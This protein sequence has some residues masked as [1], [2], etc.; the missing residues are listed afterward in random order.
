MDKSF[1]NAEGTIEWIATDIIC[2]IQATYIWWK[3]TQKLPYK[4]RQ[5]VTLSLKTGT[6]TTLVHFF[7]K[8]P[9]SLHCESPN[10]RW[11]CTIK[12][13][14]RLANFHSSSDLFY[15]RPS[16]SN[17]H[18]YTEFQPWNH[19]S[20]LPHLS[21]TTRQ[22]RKVFA[23][24]PEPETTLL[25]KQFVHWSPFI[26]NNLSNDHKTPCKNRFAIIQT[27]NFMECL[28]VKTASSSTY[29]FPKMI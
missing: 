27:T 2:R 17:R 26:W 11:S 3:T 12:T 23:C 25:T 4:W 13:I 7:D 1:H 8:P 19:L 29:I 21:H 10:S 20:N 16:S 22:K 15:S 18:L 14:L 6:K 5:E 28:K 9:K 24:V